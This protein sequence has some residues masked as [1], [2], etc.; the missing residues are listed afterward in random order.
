[1]RAKVLLTVLASAAAAAGCG[2][3]GGS[4]N[5]DVGPMPEGGSYTGV[6][7]SPQYGEMHMV[8][9]GS[10]VVGRYQKD[11]RQGRIQ[12]TVQGDVLRFEWT[13]ARQMVAGVP[14]TTRGRGY[15]RYT[16]DQSD[17]HNILGEWGIDDSE[18]GGG[19]WNAYK[20]KNRRP[21]VE[22][23]STGGEAGGDDLGSDDL[24]SDDDLGGDDLGGGGGGGG[25]GAPE[26]EDDLDPALD[27]LDL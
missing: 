6:W 4:A 11:E 5:I 13:E 7:H 26:E 15:F 2:G 24:G 14:Q 10:A 1:M 19:P 3:G 23:A 21:E 17:T 25:G 16:I 27:G 22:P 12:G 18:T 20:L 9:T 8:Q